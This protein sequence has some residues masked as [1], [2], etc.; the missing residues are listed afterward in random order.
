MNWKRFGWCWNT[1]NIDHVKTCV[2]SMSVTEHLLSW[3]IFTIIRKSVWVPETPVGAIQ[4][5]FRSSIDALV[6]KYCQI[7]KQN[8]ISKPVL[9]YCL[10][11]GLKHWSSI[12]SLCGTISKHFWTGC[13]NI[14]SLCCVKMLISKH[15]GTKSIEIF[16]AY[17]WIIS[18]HVGLGHW[19]ILSP[20]PSET[21]HL[22]LSQPVLCENAYIR[23]CG[24]KKLWNIPSQ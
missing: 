15:F 7:S 8:A 12:F 1:F 5:L 3:N 6:F 4:Y 10:K 21:K 2:W 11:D 14:F 17:L 18:K 20:I 13:W 23:T 19:N 22:G 16:S 9:K 24:I